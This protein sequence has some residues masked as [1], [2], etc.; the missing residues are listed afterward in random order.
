MIGVIN[1]RITMSITA[2]RNAISHNIKEA[3]NV[4][5]FGPLYQI[6]LFE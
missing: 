3:K 2:F 4:H 6:S 1:R 5:V